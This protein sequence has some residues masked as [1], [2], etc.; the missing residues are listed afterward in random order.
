MVVIKEVLLLDVCVIEILAEDWVKRP[1]ERT[2]AFRYG[3]SVITGDGLRGYFV[4]RPTVEETTHESTFFLCG[5]LSSI[6]SGSVGPCDGI[7]MA[8]SRSGPTFDQQTAKRYSP[9]DTGDG[10]LSVCVSVYLPSPD[11]VSAIVH[12]VGVPSEVGQLKETPRDASHFR[13]DVNLGLV[14]RPPK[15]SL[16]LRRGEVRVLLNRAGES[17]T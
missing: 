6:S 10:T 9:P 3:T 17:L 4:G 14:L 2:A 1:K 16:F 15:D 8:S 5:G 12:T 7:G 13:E 11:V